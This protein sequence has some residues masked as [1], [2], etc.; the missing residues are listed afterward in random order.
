ME[1]WPCG[2]V[3]KKDDTNVNQHVGDG[4]GDKEWSRVNDLGKRVHLK[5]KI[6]SMIL[7]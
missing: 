4:T 3:L 6:A 5:R 2:Q 1:C 7:A